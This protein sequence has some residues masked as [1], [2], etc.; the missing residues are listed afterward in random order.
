MLASSP[1]PRRA[2]TLAA[3]GALSALVAVALLVWSAPDAPVPRAAARAADEPRAQATSGPELAARPARADAGAREQAAPARDQEPAPEPEQRAAPRGDAVLRGRVVDDRGQ[4]VAAFSTLLTRDTEGARLLEA[5]RDEDGRFE[6]DALAAGRWRLSVTAPAHV[7]GAPLDV[8]LPR[9]SEV[10]V[11][12]HRAARVSGVVLLPDGAPAAEAH[13]LALPPRDDGRVAWGAPTACDARGRF[14]LELPFVGQGRIAARA[15]GHADSAALALDVGP[16]ELRADVTLELR[17]AG[18]IRC[19]V[20]DE[21]GGPLPGARVLGQERRG[22]A[23]WERTSDARGTLAVR[24]LP[25]GTYDVVAELHTQDTRRAVQAVVELAPGATAE[26]V[27]SLAPAAPIVLAGYV[28]RGGAPLAR[29]VAQVD[30]ESGRE[31]GATAEVRDGV[32]EVTLDGAGTYRVSVLL[33]ESRGVWIQRVAVSL[34]ERFELDVAL[35]GG[36]LSGTVRG[37]DGA[38]RPGVGVA[39]APDVESGDLSAEVSYGE[40]STDA[41]GRFRFTDLRAG[42]YELTAPTGGEGVGEYAR[43][44]L[45]GLDVRADE[46]RTGVLLRLTRA[47]AL[48]GVVRDA[49]GR[50]CSSGRVLLVDE[51]GKRLED[52]GCEETGHY[53]LRH[54]PA[55]PVRVVALGERDI[56]AVQLVVLAAGETRAQDLRLAATGAVAVRVRAR[57]GAFLGGALRVV[58]EAGIDYASLVDRAR[59]ATVEPPAELLRVP[60]G[61]YVVSAENHS[62]ARAE[63]A[64]DVTPGD[65][66]RVELVYP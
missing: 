54:L 31:F 1:H 20:L 35:P 63:R 34:V 14:A 10:R 13:V 19:R 28:H 27:L 4:P 60:P 64:V 61:R 17:T 2:W 39:L 51:R 32:F 5:T 22:A 59:D 57:G 44:T 24:D 9:A 66:L 62:G 29:G 25:A 50:P 30:C 7:A 16:G 11:E 52:T 12:L 23:V 3:A 47:A 21:D 15:A 55:G 58:D 46:E 42:R 49:R 45:A 65:V 48:S 56:S 26:V 8:Q 38:P 41:D 6:R 43:V 33:G 37:L 40:Q 18:A 36:A 53:V